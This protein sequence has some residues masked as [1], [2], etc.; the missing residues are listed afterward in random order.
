MR[1]I[2]YLGLLAMVVGCPAC[3]WLFGS[4]PSSPTGP[5]RP[6]PALVICPD[7]TTNCTSPNGTGVYTA[8]HG[9][10]GIGP[11][12]LLITHFIN[13]PSSPPNTSR[14]AFD[15]RFF[16]FQGTQTWGRLPGLGAVVRA[17][18][19]GALGL[20]VTAV[21][22]TSTTLQWTLFDSAH[23]TSIPV[24]GAQLADLTVYVEFTIFSR[25]TK[26]D[27]RTYALRFQPSASGGTPSV[28]TYNLTWRDAR[29]PGAPP[30]ARYCADAQGNTD[31]VVFQ[32]GIDVDPIVGSVDRAPAS[33]N[34]VTMSCR[35]GAIATVYS[36]GYGYGDA[37]GT[38]PADT[39]YFDAGIQ[40]KRASYC[41][42]A[43]YFTV[44]G[45]DIFITD[46]KGIQPATPP[47]PSIEAWWTPTGASCVNLA[48]MRHSAMGFQG[49]CKGNP[50]PACPS[51][52]PAPP[53]LGDA[54]KHPGP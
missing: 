18:Y 3:R 10:A 43:Q 9:A 32:R 11:Y 40:M 52:L 24:S 22:E 5:P 26:G 15:G 39:H 37:S 45:T 29:D 48:N 35:L 49:S 30:P 4:G 21:S 53:Y 27:T 25:Q 36:W 46:D 8:E 44:A 47:P 20:P 2:S 33:A 38:P 54:P 19:Q 1:R 42:D 50:L 14:V 23:A 51:A 17:D 28:K 31:P 7:G 16:D 13:Q 12:Q 6:P 34:L 41:G